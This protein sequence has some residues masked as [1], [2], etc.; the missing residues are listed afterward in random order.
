M[1]TTSDGDKTSGKGSEQLTASKATAAQAARDKNTTDSSVKDRTETF[2]GTPAEAAATYLH[3]PGEVAPIGLVIGDDA[4]EAWAA[5]VKADDRYALP[6]PDDH[7]ATGATGSG[8]GSPMPA[9][10]VQY[11][12]GQNDYISTVFDAGQ[13]IVQNGADPTG[14]AWK[15]PESDFRRFA[16]AVRGEP[17]PV[18]ERASGPTQYEE[19]AEMLRRTRE[20]VQADR[21]ANDRARERAAAGTE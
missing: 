8:G 7:Q 19:A 17:I 6:D 9:L 11:G 3:S 15:F 4:M 1:T 12:P 14:K 2:S 10:I 5:Q 18:D 16:A 13:A 21:D 20:S